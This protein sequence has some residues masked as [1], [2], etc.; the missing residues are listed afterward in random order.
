[1]NTKTS[2]IVSA[3]IACC[4][5]IVYFWVMSERGYTYRDMMIVAWPSNLVQDV[6]VGFVIYYI[7]ALVICFCI[8]EIAK[9]AYSK[10]KSGVMKEPAGHMKI[11]LYKL[12]HR[13]GFYTVIGLIGLA[14]SLHNSLINVVEPLRYLVAHGIY[15]LTSAMMLFMLLFT[16]AFVIGEVSRLI[17]KG[18][19]RK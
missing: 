8:I 4:S 14:F 11:N 15:S 10:H 3:V 18:Y 19:T 5:P 2:A 13:I 17:V 1:M 16:P 7:P 12:K 6:S 9:F